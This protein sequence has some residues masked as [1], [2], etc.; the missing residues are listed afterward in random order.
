[1][2]DE[3]RPYSKEMQ[4]ARAERRYTRKV[5]SPKRWAAIAD[6]KQG[7]CRVTGAPPP[8]ELAHI[9]AR[10]Q[11]GPD[12]AW[13][14]VPLSREAHARFDQRDPETCR[15]VLESLTDEEYAGLVEFAGEQVF[16]RRFGI[17]F[18]RAS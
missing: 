2:S 9:I 12:V 18:E 5:A 10:S 7:P 3:A 11:G 13:N 4:L 16:E 1:M 17:R 15:A 8:N 6:A 14:I